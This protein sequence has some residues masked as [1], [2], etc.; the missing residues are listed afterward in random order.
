[1]TKKPKKPKK[2]EKYHT[3]ETRSL[4]K[5]LLKQEKAKGQIAA[6]LG[7]GSKATQMIID[8]WELEPNLII[9]RL[10]GVR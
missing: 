3:P 2:E 6:E 9:P 7:F 5:K 1:M 8:R 10:R 4:I